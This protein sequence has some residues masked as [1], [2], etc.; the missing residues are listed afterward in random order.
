MHFCEMRVK[1]YNTKE[2]FYIHFSQCKWIHSMQSYRG[3]NSQ[4][5]DWDT[6]FPGDS[7]LD[8]HGPFLLVLVNVSPESLESVSPES[9]W[10]WWRGIISLLQD[11][12]R[13]PEKVFFWHLKLNWSPTCIILSHKWK[14]QIQMD[15]GV[16]F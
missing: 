2:Q 11:S 7:G 9:L 1:Y 13:R 5:V 16:A 14:I 4:T 8:V 6:V 3:F 12:K 10:K 15:Y